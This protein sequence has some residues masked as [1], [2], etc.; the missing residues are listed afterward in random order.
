MQLLLYP[1]QCQ[2]F[3][4]FFKNASSHFCFN[5]SF[6]LKYFFKYY[7]S[8]IVAQCHTHCIAKTK[9]IG[10]ILFEASSE[11]S[12]TV[13]P[14]TSQATPLTTSRPTAATAPPAVTSSVQQPGS[15]A[16]AARNITGK[17]G[18][19]LFSVT[20]LG[21]FRESHAGPSENNKISVASWLPSRPLRYKDRGSL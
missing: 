6:M 12:A 7:S 9:T 19:T 13:G 16:T 2:P 21:S 11:A 20:R 1:L 8:E 15:Q 10:L 17:F 14:S 5:I 3:L 4:M 18:N